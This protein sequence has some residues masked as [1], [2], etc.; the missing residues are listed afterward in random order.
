MNWWPSSLRLRIIVGFVSTAIF[1]S[2]LFGLISFVFAYNVEDRIFAGALSAEVEIQ[3][4][5]WEKNKQLAKPSREY[6]RI[7]R[8]TSELPNDLKSQFATDDAETEYF[9]TDGRYYHVNRFTLPDQGGNAIAVAEVGPYLVVRPRRDK[10]IISLLVVTTIV[11]LISGI[12][13]CFMAS[14]AVAPLS[15]LAADVAKHGDNAVPSIDSSG[16]RS[17]E[18]AALATGLE[19]A[20]DRVRSFVARERAFT[21]DASHELR[22]P[23]AVIRSGAELLWSNKVDDSVAIAPIKRIE[24]AAD[25]MALTL[26]LLLTLAREDGAPQVSAPL[27][28]LV[29][30]SIFYASERFANGNIRVAVDLDENQH[31]LMNPVIVQLILNNIIGNAFQHADH[32]LLTVSGNGQTLI[33]TDTGPGLGE[34]GGTQISKPFQKGDASTGD[35]L[36]LSIVRR[37]CSQSKIG[38]SMTSSDGAGTCFTFDFA[39]PG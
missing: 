31:V 20:F 39:V 22:T 10:M 6:M 19:N 13:G 1:T 25:D 35:G 5:H 29:E 34:C 9:G 11:A 17:K 21:R 26:D 16:Y 37:L 7:F 4:M 2:A 38:L 24:T 8:S 30:K 18:I 36:G 15:K 12:I 23:L 3:Q 28:P 14:R 33:V 32:S 27:L